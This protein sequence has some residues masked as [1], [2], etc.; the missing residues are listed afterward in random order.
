VST[1]D[2]AKLVAALIAQLE[3]QLQTLLRSAASALESATHEDAR[4]ENEYDTRGLEAG[5]LAG[6]Q[7]AR[8][9]QIR[10]EMAQLR[11]MPVRAWKKNEPVNVGAL[12]ELQDDD[13]KR[14]LYFLAI[15]RGATLSIGGKIVQ[16]LTPVS[17]LGRELLGKH[18][19]DSV[20]LEVR[21]Q[22]RG[23]TI[24]KVS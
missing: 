24:D 21:G 6:A 4:A 18:A 16:V 17:P 20:E 9:E 14:G 3:Q 8:A 15:G 5:Y 23:Y 13:G 10:A 11:Q 2:K 12:L 22:P 7:A 1:A 19:G